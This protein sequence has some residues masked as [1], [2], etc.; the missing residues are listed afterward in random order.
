MAIEAPVWMKWKIDGPFLLKAFRHYRFLIMPDLS[1]PLP[2]MKNAM[3]QLI[4]E[5]RQSGPNIITRC[6]QSRSRRLLIKQICI[7]VEDT[8]AVGPHFDDLN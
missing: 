3:A 6:M 4:P 7:T 8:G 2:Y 1:L 5:F